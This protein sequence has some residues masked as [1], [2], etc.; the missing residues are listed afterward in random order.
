MAK[1]IE[2]ELYETI[3]KEKISIFA[4]EWIKHERNIPE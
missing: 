3:N 2:E 1:P 4:V